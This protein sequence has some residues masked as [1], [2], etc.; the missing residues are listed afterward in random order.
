MS[1]EAERTE[2]IRSIIQGRRFLGNWP[3]LP[4]RRRAELAE[5][6]G[7]R[8]ETLRLMATWVAANVRIRANPLLDR[9]IKAAEQGEM[10]PRWEPLVWSL[11]KLARESTKDSELCQTFEALVE[12]ATCSKILL[13]LIVTVLELVRREQR[14]GQPLQIDAALDGL[15]AHFADA[16]GREFL[17]RAPMAYTWG[18]ADAVCAMLQYA[19]EPKDGDDTVAGSK[20]AVSFYSGLG[21]REGPELIPYLVSA[22]SA[23]GNEVE[24]Q[25]LT[26]IEY[27]RGFLSLCARLDQSPL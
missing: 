27:A 20:N 21:E 23:L 15:V 11:K 8:T 5:L 24:Y 3:L 4:W 9:T 7:H 14:D 25:A 22:R 10:D 1:D 16:G 2:L 13:N 6:E 26:L 17:H 19:R 12:H 18:E